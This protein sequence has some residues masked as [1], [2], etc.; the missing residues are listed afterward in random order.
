M[1]KQIRRIIV[2]IILSILGGGA[3]TS[4]QDFESF[5]KQQ[6]ELF[7]DYRQKTRSEWENY[8]QKVN[9]DFAAFLER[10]WVHRN[11]EKPFVEPKKE[12]DVPPVVL[13]DLDNDLPE[14]NLIEVDITFPVIEDEPIPIA[15]VVYRPKPSEKEISFS[16]Y[17]TPGSVRFDMAKRIKLNGNDEKAVSKF[18]RDVSN[19]TYDNVLSDCQKIREERDFSDWAYFKITEKVS[20]TLYGTRNERV[21]FHAWLLSQSG[22]RVR[23]GRDSGNIYLL[24]NTTSILF[25]KMFWE[26]SGANY[27]LLEDVNL[28][29]MYVIDADFPGTSPLRLRMKARNDF[30]NASTPLRILTSTTSPEVRAT[31]S[32]NNNLLAFLQDVPI[33]AIEGTAVTDF[34]KYADMPLSHEAEQG[35]YSVLKESIKGKT[36]AEAVN[37]L[38]NFVQTAFKYETDKEA[39]GKERTFFPEETLYYPYSDC[40]D[41]AILFCRLVKDLMGLDV[42]FILYPGHLATAVHFSQDY[43][44]DYF[45]VKGKRYLVCDPTYINA[46]IGC[47]MMGMDNNTAQV[48]MF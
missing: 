21:V 27:Y 34:L 22:F 16:F 40:E 10:A 31:V 14:D 35:L 12:P 39:W 1:I 42:A 47:T 46:P 6:E 3:I 13:T 28:D 33:S 41:R 17:G 11:P 38:L 26:L 4:A 24:L 32:C 8:R 37:L 29:S 43:P 2:T 7:Q 18:W 48:L 19:E 5:K 44:G 9:D 30:D 36:E 20:E 15:P 25:D 45:L 23:L